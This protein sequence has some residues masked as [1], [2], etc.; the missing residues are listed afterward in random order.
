MTRLV[1]Q[2]LFAVLF[3]AVLVLTGVGTTSVWAQEQAPAVAAQDAGAAQTSRT[4]LP[5]SI[6]TSSIESLG[7]QLAIDGNRLAAAPSIW[8]SSPKVLLYERSSPSSPW[9]HTATVEPPADPLVY[10][11]YAGFG[12]ALALEG[13]TLFVCAKDAK[14]SGQ[15]DGGAI[16]V[17][18][19]IAGRWE[20]ASVIGV[21]ELGRLFAFGSTLA[22]D[23]DLLVA[24]AGNGS[25]MA[26][27]FERSVSNPSVWTQAAR[28]VP[29]TD[30]RFYAGAV[31]V[32]DG[33]VAVGDRGN[34]VA[35]VFERNLGGPNAWG[36]AA[37][38]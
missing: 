33:S 3:V 36:E 32:H 23:G 31:A 38:F 24:G 30:T 25:H 21:L 12:Y 4:L 16:H 35:Y 1:R 2:I 14:V 28:L 19:L 29:R 10:D 15:A 20:H 7:V 6:F 27:V 34:S 9:Q 37:K 26:Y 18:R 17:Y 13:D 8:L 5:N 22:V 11:Q